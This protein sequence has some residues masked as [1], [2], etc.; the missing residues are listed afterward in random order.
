M[1]FRAV[2]K[3]LQRLYVH[4]MTLIFI[5]LRHYFSS[6]PDANRSIHQLNST[7]K[8]PDLWLSIRDV[9]L[10]NQ[11]VFPSEVISIHPRKVFALCEPAALI[12]GL[13]QSSVLLPGCASLYQ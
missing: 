13:N 11:A 1:L 2:A 3:L 7:A 6:C 12:Q 4:K 8:G 5:V 9:E 10:R